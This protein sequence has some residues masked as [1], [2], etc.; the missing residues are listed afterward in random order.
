MKITINEH[1]MKR[2]FKIAS[3]DYYSLDGLKALL[4]FY[5]DLDADTGVETEFDV[6]EICRQWTE[7][8]ETSLFD[9]ADLISDYGFLLLF[10][11]W[12]EDCEECTGRERNQQEYIKALLE[13]IESKTIVL[14][15]TNGNVLVMSY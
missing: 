15:A 11:E 3:R 9:Y 4:D 8:G 13:K 7:Y 5:D 14:K 12:A 1:D 6:M 10:D 2:A